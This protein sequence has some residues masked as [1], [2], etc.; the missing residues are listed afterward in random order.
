MN[1]EP[2]FY[3]SV[4]QTLIAGLRDLPL[5]LIVTLGREQDPAD[6]GPQPTNVH[7]ERYIPQ[8]L[9]LR[10]CDLMVMHG[11]SND[12]LAAMDVGMPLVVVPLIADQFYNAH[13]TQN[14]QLGQVVPHTRL[15]PARV[16]AAVQE[17]LDDPTYRQTAQRLQTE[18]HALP[19]MEYAV[20][21]VE[22]LVETSNVN[23]T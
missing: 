21:L 1:G 8:S 22:R 3:P 18:M 6:F 20:E 14:I 15:T 16:R 19:G 2:E 23:R 5:N 13:V 11:G 17:V 12:L 4:M 7:I 10:H 9:L